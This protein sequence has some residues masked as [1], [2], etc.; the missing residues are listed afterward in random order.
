MYQIGAGPDYNLES[1]PDQPGPIDTS[2][3]VSKAF[4]TGL[5]S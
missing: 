1:I 4:P 5:P 3:T 2:A